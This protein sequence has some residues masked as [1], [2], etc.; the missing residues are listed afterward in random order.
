MDGTPVLAALD[1]STLFF[2]ALVCFFAGVVGGLSGFGTGILVAIFITPM[3]GPKVLIPLMAVVMI[4]NNS[5]RVWFFRR[6][7]NLKIASTVLL[8]AIPGAYVGVKIYEH[9][10]APIL[11]VLIGLVIAT[12]IPLKYWLRSRPTPTDLL[13]LNLFGIGY[14]VLSSVVL[15]AGM[16]L[17]PALLGFGLTGPAL[18][19]TDAFIA[20]GIN[21]AK[22]IFFQRLDALNMP[23]ALF[24][25]CAGLATVPGVALASKLSEKLG[26]TIHTRIVEILV[27]IGGIHMGYKGWINWMS[28][29]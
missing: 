18:V 2:G 24:G 10:N 4:V 23:V 12:S 5:S 22:A 29:V 25:I 28:A 7:L 21:V 6:G 20:V 19:A 17:M 8:T 15:G 27:I 11:Q 14:G 13:T 26:V 3:V 9:L 16:I 1:W